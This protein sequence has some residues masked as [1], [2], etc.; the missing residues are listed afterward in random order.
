MSSKI[1]TAA[2]T[3]LIAEPVEVE[4]DISAGLSSFTI[5]GLPDTAVQESRE[6]IRAAVKNSGLDFPRTRVTVNLA[7]ADV[8]KEGPAYDLPIVIAILER[9]GAL[10]QGIPP[11]SLFVGELALDGGVRPV[12]GVLS[13]A[14]DASRRGVNTL[15][16]GRGN[17]TEAAL[18]PDITVFPVDSLIQLVDHLEGRIPI[19]PAPRTEPTP[20]EPKEVVDL[21]SIRGQDQAKRALEIA[22]AGGHNLLFTGP[23]GSGKTLLARAL[24]GILPSLTLPEAL[25]VTQIW[26]VAGALPAGTPLLWERPFRSPHHTASGI[27][28]VGGG[29]NPKPGE[30]SLAHRGVLFLDELPEFSRSVLENLRQPIEDGFVTVSRA[31][32]T[33]RFPAKFML[34]GSLNPCPC[35][36]SSDPGSQCTCTPNQIVKY[37]KKISGPLLDRIDLV[38]EAP[39]VKFDHL[40]SDA[41]DEPSA[42]VRSRVVQARTTQINRFRGRGIITNAEMSVKDLKEFCTIDTETKELIRTA[43][44]Q[45][46]LSAR[47]Y[48]RLLKVAR[49]IADLAG[50]ENITHN[51]VAEAITYRAKVE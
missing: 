29:T 31:A 7:P 15:F 19:E 24:P 10:T 6:R 44:H 4:C 38:T 35:G 42:R 36:Y 20:S 12:S 9:A 37:Q 23:P 14:L 33:L 45:F 47:A 13:I 34:V 40:S 49:T 48:H 39:R 5:V 50:L 3:G 21:S 25:E 17:A 2:L 26:S 51:N 1:Y 46:R 11:S 32:G 43:V 30:V 41:P 16:V 8:R 27:A 22:A 18:A 28:L